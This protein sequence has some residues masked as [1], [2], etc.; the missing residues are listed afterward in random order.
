MSKR[1]KQKSGPLTVAEVNIH[2]WQA[3]R[4]AWLNGKDELVLVDREKVSVRTGR[5][6]IER[7]RMQVRTALVVP[8]DLDQRRALSLWLTGPNG[9]R[10]KDLSVVWAKLNGVAA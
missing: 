7:H 3:R 6:A 2:A 4:A 5:T 8:P 9:E 1:K 10:A